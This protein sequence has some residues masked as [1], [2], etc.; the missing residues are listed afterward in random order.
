MNHYLITFW[1]KPNGKPGY[2]GY[3]PHAGPV[4]DFVKSTFDDTAGQYHLVSALEIDAEEYNWA[5]D[6]L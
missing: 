3:A 1:Y 2:M 5:Q 4:L 6:H